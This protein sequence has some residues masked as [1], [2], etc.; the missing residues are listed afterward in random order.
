[1]TKDKPNTKLRL[2]LL[3]ALPSSAQ[4]Q[5]MS[6][7]KMNGGLF[8][9]ANRVFFIGNECVLLWS[10]HYIETESLIKPTVP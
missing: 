4:S 10:G 5:K 7:T 6:Q 3:A 9:L 8:D 1:V 2:I